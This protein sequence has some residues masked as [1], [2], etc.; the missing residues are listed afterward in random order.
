VSCTRRFTARSWRATRGTVAPGTPYP[1]SPALMRCLAK[2]PSAR[3]PDAKALKEALTPDESVPELPAKVRP[4]GLRLALP[5]VRPR[6]DV[7]SR[8][9]EGARGEADV[10]CR[11]HGRVHRDPGQTPA[12]PA[13]AGHRP[14]GVP[15]AGLE[16]RMVSPRPAPAR[17]PVGAPA[18]SGSGGAPPGRRHHRRMGAS[19]RS[20]PRHAHG[21][22]QRRRQGQETA[23]RDASRIM[24]S[25]LLTRRRGA[26]A[27]RRMATGSSR[28]PCSQTTG[29]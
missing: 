13:V 18:T 15:A 22:R 11:G 16:A 9:S 5:H 21:R 8:A 19:G 17:G 25:T 29:T 26:Q 14:P 28:S 4:S 12:R 10:S 7:G 3:W 24:S 27:Q 20:T 6:P 2:D 23:P 1:L